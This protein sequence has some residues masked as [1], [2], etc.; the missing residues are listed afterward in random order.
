M[1]KIIK[2]GKKY[3]ALQG[4][5]ADFNANKAFPDRRGN[6]AFSGYSKYFKDIGDRRVGWV[7]WVLVLD[8]DGGTVCCNIKGT[9]KYANL[10]FLSYPR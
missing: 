10:W 3:I 1:N 2:T 6:G 9:E 4:E 7:G 8:L 5:V